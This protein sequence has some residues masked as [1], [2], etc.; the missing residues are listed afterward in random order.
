M[1]MMAKARA[2]A[3]IALI[4]YWGKRNSRLNLPAVGSISLTLSELW[5]ETTV[6]FDP[7][8][9]E[10]FFTLN[11][12]PANVEQT[13]RISKFLDLVRQ[14]K[15]VTYG[16]HV[17]SKNNFPTAA[18]LASSASG[19]AALSVAA[20]FALQLPLSPKELTILARQG[21]GS[22][23]R[24]IFGGFVEMHAG[25]KSDGSD[26]FAEP[27]EPADYWDVRLLIGVTSTES[28]KISSTYGMSLSRKTSPYFKAW[29][30]SQEKDLDEMR[31][32]IRK[33]DFERLGELSEHSCLKM[34]AVALSSNPGILYWNA[35]TVEAMHAVR[36]LRAQGVQAY[37]TIDAGPQI[38]VL[39]L[40]QDQERVSQMLTAIDGIKQVIVNAPGPDAEVLEVV[41]R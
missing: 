23:A 17:N 28:K 14:Y 35:T 24:S 39:C 12:V 4:K 32:A 29:V 31:Q 40:P 41:N 8:F 2:N 20:A 16:A 3:N 19:F 18:G 22:A 15:G 30:R 27:L 34:H 38:K 37:F 7:D 1:E 9:H 33:K 5:T 13:Q 11:G 26:S 21:S 10:D 36:E 6:R 25:K